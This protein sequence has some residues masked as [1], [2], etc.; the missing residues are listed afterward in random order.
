MVCIQSD[1][2]AEFSFSGLG[3]KPQVGPKINTAYPQPEKF[4]SCKFEA[5]GLTR[6]GMNKLLILN[7][8]KT[9]DQ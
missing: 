6:A 2:Q 7:N 1:G 5:L 8:L 9:V 4:F 3:G